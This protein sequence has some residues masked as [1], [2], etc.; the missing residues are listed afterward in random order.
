MIHKLRF[1][2]EGRQRAIYLRADDEFVAR[3]KT[4][5]ADF[6]SPHRKSRE[7]RRLEAE[8]RQCLRKVK[9]H[10]EPQLLPAGFHFHGHAI[11]RMRPS[12]S[13]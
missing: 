9:A 3:I 8:A 13:D 10:L 2:V 6:Q 12:A 5:I 4:E 1:R 11:R 7:L